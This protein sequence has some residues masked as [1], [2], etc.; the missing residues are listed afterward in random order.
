MVE[1]TAYMGGA[2]AVNLGRWAP[3]H[4]AGQGD[5]WQAWQMT[6]LDCL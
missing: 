4:W 3:G 5:G 6:G 2:W 1:V